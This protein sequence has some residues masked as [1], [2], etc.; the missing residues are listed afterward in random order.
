[1]WTLRTSLS[2]PPFVSGC[3]R[4]F[5]RV[6]ARFVQVF[7]YSFILNFFRRKPLSL[8]EVTQIWHAG[9]RGAIAYVLCITFPSQ[10]ADLVRVRRMRTSRALLFVEESA[11]VCGAGFSHHSTRPPPLTPP[12]PS[13]VFSCVHTGY[14]RHFPHHCVHHFPPWWHHH[15]FPEVPQGLCLTCPHSAAWHGVVLE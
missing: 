2:H 6:T 7:L 8:R 5:V 14:Q 4:C 1:M 3:C 13:C 9:L 10:H 12:P 15:V 11:L